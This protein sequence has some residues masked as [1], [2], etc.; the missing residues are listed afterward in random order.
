MKLLFNNSIQGINSE[1][2]TQMVLL[3]RKFRNVYIEPFCK[4]YNVSYVSYPCLW[5]IDMATD[6][7]I[8]IDWYGSYEFYTAIPGS[9]IDK[10][11]I[12]TYSRFFFC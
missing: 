9:L 11:Y 10:K 1:W 5:F 8:D 3:G 4:K 6:K 2:E 7:I 12:A